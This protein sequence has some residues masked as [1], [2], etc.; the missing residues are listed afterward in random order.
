M[1]AEAENIEV[2]ISND[3]A[4]EDEMVV[5]T[6]SLSVGRSLSA[7]VVTTAGP[8]DGTNC[9]AASGAANAALVG[10]T[11]GLWVGQCAGPAGLADAGASF[12][13]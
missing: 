6:V 13:P 1:K 9:G 11:P 12:G 8:M 2:S 4:S 3:R 10:T 7:S 5:P